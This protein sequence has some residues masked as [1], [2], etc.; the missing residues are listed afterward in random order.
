[1]WSD[2][3]TGE[4]FL[5]FTAVAETAAEMIL[6]A[7]GQPLSIGVSGSWGVGKSSM[8][9]LVRQSL[10][11]KGQDKY[12]F[13][14][15]NAWLYQGY[16]DARAALMDVIARELLEHAKKTET[17]VETAKKLLKRVNWVRVAGLVG[18][19]AASAATG[20]FVPPG[21]ISEGWNAVTSLVGGNRS[22]DTLGHLTHAGGEAKDAAGKAVEASKGLLNPEEEPTSPPQ[23]I[24]ALRNHFEEAL[25]EMGVTLVVFIDD[26]DRCLPNTAIATLEAI[27]LF[28]FLKHTAFIIAADEKMI[29][30]AVRH[31]FKDLELDDDLVTN[32]FDKLIQVPIQVPPL[33]TQEVRAYMMLLYIE[34]SGIEPDKRELLRKAVCK[35]LSEAWQGKRVDRDFIVE[36]IQPCAPELMSQLALADR[37]APLMAGAEKIAGNPR[38]IKRFLNTLSIRLSIAKA[39][40]VQANEAAV[41]K[42]LL[43]ERY[44][45]SAAYTHLVRAITEDE[46]GKPRF[47]KDW[48]EA[49]ESGGRLEGLPAEWDHPAIREWLTLEPAFADMDLRGVV[50]VSR[51]HTPIITM[52]DRL[53]PEA[54]KALPA[55]LGLRTATNTNVTELVRAVPRHER[56]RIMEKLLDRAKQEHEWGVPSIFHALVTVAEVD[57]EQA[58]RL[59]NFFY[60][61]PEQQVKAGLIPRI[62]K[63]PWAKRALDKW[64]KSKSVEERVKRTIKS[65]REE[66]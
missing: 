6:S 14:E 58:E 17:G 48:E 33:G 51:E 61:L 59:G 34:R 30:Q 8:I 45:Q 65:E 44:G 31:H 39:Q 21:F 29:R 41:A 60:E 50:H 63:A 46:E 27:R 36:Q 57:P 40:G 23:E 24:Q 9:R 38:L 10:K 49:A 56:P 47:L 25:A 64:E 37:L 15:F 43:F 20:G 26:L 12:L 28:L 3:E 16:D 2:N 18:S 11:E 5:N 4:D 53:S 62:A 13:V 19:V 32:Y 54:T 52:A 35:Q 7:N 22:K 66:A 1:M 55:L 42:M